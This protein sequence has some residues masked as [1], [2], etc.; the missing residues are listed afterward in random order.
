MTKTTT[1]DRPLSQRYSHFIV[2]GLLAL[3]TIAC[4]S[5]TSKSPKLYYEGLMIKSPPPSADE[6]ARLLSI[7]SQKLKQ[8]TVYVKRSGQKQ[9][10]F[11][12][13]IKKLKTLT[14]PELK[15][16]WMALDKRYI[17]AEL[18]LKIITLKKDSV[19]VTVWIDLKGTMTVE[20]GQWKVSH[21]PSGPK[22]VEQRWNVG[23]LKVKAGAKWS[24]R[25]LRSINLALSKLSSEE[26]KLIRGIPF[27]RK[28]KG[29]SSSQAALYIQEGDC[30]AFIQVFN[31][32]I[33]SEK[34]TFSG[35][36]KAALPA[37]VAPILHEIGHAL[38]FYP[39][40]KALCNSDHLVK[41]YNQK[42]A[43][44]NKASGAKQ[45]RLNKELDQDLKAVNRS[46]KQVER[47][48]GKGP[49][50]KAYL[51]VRGKKKG[52]T[53]YGESSAA[54]SFAESFALYRVDPKALKRVFPKVY[55]WFQS[56]GHLKAIRKSL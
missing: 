24:K 53:P 21:I 42:V 28:Q 36:A 56:N 15:A 8:R 3:S 25:A 19:P 7:L 45:K 2:L 33:K 9:K 4:G 29:T 47:L 34:Y 12:T 49:V 35:E 52:P 46:K 11:G 44:A 13:K 5:S 55:K 14:H 23:P 26:L 48:S 22:E 30:D 41:A 10:V 27:V 50:L 38:H 51:K 1:S 6:K 18:D 31:L 43:K 37:T 16:L 39:F 40:R 17:G 54:E 32:A 20:V